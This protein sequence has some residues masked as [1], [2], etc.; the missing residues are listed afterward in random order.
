VVPYR[1]D[2]YALI[3]G[4]GLTVGAI[5]RPQ[6]SSAVT[7]LI[8]AMRGNSILSRHGRWLLNYTTPT[9]I[10]HQSRCPALPCLAL[11][12]WASIAVLSRTIGL[13]LAINYTLLR[14]VVVDKTVTGCAQL[15]YGKRKL[16]NNVE[17]AVRTH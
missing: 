8:N 10:L 15:F 1:H 3:V 17:N 14:L 4:A 7:E 11:P 6:Q 5:L 13:G 12:W 9:S 2:I 16:Q